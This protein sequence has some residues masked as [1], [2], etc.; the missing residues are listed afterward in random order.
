MDMLYGM[1]CIRPE[2]ATMLIS[3]GDPIPLWQRIL[4]WVIALAA[5]LA[6]FFAFFTMTSRPTFE[7]RK[8]DWLCAASHTDYITT[9]VDMGGGKTVFL[10][11]I[12]TPVT[13]CD[14]YERAR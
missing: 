6:V 13:T 4:T 2:S 3:A 11:P 12:T 9:Y 8:D 5:A 10:V 7:L 1:T 14:R